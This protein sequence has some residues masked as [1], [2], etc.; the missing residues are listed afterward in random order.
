MPRAP[1]RQNRHGGG[2]GRQQQQSPQ[3]NTQKEDNKKEV[4]LPVYSPDVECGMPC[5][6]ALGPERATLA[7]LKY[8]EPRPVAADMFPEETK[9]ILDFISCA[10]RPSGTPDGEE[11]HV[12]SSAYVSGSNHVSFPRGPSHV[13]SCRGLLRLIQ[14]VIGLHEPNLMTLGAIKTIQ[15]MIDWAFAKVMYAPTTLPQ[16]VFV[17][18]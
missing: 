13:K 7:I 6:L 16:Y 2:R 5:E 15:V 12:S 10:S 3:K 17:T 8:L 1:R 9:R 18:L 4:L 11:D 14:G